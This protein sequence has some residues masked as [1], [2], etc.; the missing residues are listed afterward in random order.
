MY[1]IQTHDMHQWLLIQ[2]YV[3]LMMGAESA[4][5][6]YSDLAVTNKN[7]CQSSISLVLYIISTSV[8]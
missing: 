7:Y 3:L 8:P 6:I 2:L 5:N 4:R 1:I